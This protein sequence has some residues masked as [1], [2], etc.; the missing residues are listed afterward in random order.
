ME[1]ANKYRRKFSLLIRGDTWATTPHRFWP[2]IQNSTKRQF[3]VTTIDVAQLVSARSMM[4]MDY[5]FSFSIC[6]I[7]LAF[8]LFQVGAWYTGMT[9]APIKMTLY[10]L[11][12]IHSILSY[13]IDWISDSILAGSS[14]T[15]H[16]Q[17]VMCYF[18]LVISAIHIYGV[19]SDFLVMFNPLLML[20]CSY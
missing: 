9:S 3:R 20:P 2:S 5:V 19:T 10:F 12:L 14:L 15:F 16:E 11:I 18:V 13:H 7:S 17:V 8:N 4:H 1:S 6:L